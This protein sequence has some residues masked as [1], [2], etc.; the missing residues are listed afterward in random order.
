MMNA[1]IAR[2]RRLLVR[3]ITVAEI[4][5]NPQHGDA[6]EQPLNRD[7]RQR[8]AFF[9]AGLAGKRVGA[10]QLTGPQRQDVVRHEADDD[11]REDIPRGDLNDG[12][13]QN[14]PA[15][16][17]EPDAGEEQRQRGNQIDDN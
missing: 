13:E 10:R 3:L 17:P 8:R 1:I 15:H 4:R 5:M 7:G 2:W 16:C 11:D 12:F 14:A 9:R 6:I